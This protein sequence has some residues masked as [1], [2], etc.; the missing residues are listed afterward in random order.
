MY[1][2]ICIY[3]YMHINIYMYTCV[4]IYIYEWRTGEV[5]VPLR[6]QGVCG[7]QGPT[8]AVARIGDDPHRDAGCTSLFYCWCVQCL[9]PDKY[10]YPCR[11]KEYR[12]RMNSEHVRQSG[13]DYGLGLSHFPGE[14]L[15]HLLRCSLFPCWDVP[16][17]PSRG[18]PMRWLALG[19]TAFHVWSGVSLVLCQ[20]RVATR[21]L[22]TKY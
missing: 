12:S 14:S 5:L 6:I 10:W 22:L 4:C 19:V 17:S 20:V 11:F 2:Y 18:R 16:S 8:D 3:I 1:I 7:V 15:H 13:P 21:W 9:G